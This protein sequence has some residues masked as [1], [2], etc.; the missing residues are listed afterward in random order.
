MQRLEDLHR[1]LDGTMGILSLMAR[2][3]LSKTNGGDVLCEG[4][5]AW[6]VYSD[7][8]IQVLMSEYGPLTVWPQHEHLDS[9]E[10]LV[11]V[12]GA[13]EVSVWTNIGEAKHYLAPASGIK[14]PPRT[15]HSVYSIVGGKL[16]AVCIPPEKGY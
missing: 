16:L 9:V 5:R 13:F 12:E 10:Y 14:L 11:C 6:T 4:V 8:S 3:E 1:Q 15:L 7:A 2:G